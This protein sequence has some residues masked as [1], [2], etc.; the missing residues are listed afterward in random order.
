MYPSIKGT[1]SSTILPV[2]FSGV[3]PDVATAIIIIKTIMKVNPPPPNR[4][5]FFRAEKLKLRMK[6]ILF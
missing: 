3:E 2:K 4:R 5:I 6:V 1:S